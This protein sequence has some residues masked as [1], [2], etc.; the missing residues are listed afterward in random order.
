M[1]ESKS[2]EYYRQQCILQIPFRTFIHN[3]YVYHGNDSDDKWFDYFESQN[4]TILNTD[5]DY[6]GNNDLE[7]DEIVEDCDIINNAFEM[8]SAAKNESPEQALGQRYIHVASDWKSHDIKVST[9]TEIE[10]FLNTYGFLG[11]I[12]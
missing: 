10:H 9:V 7:E 5:L 2:E 1:D 3:F 6:R 12:A 8:L 11:I 4:L